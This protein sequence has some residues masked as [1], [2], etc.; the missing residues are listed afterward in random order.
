MLSAS[1]LNVFGKPERWK[2]QLHAADSRECSKNVFCTL[3]M[4]SHHPDTLNYQLWT[5]KQDV[6]VHISSLDA[7]NHHQRESEAAWDQW[8]KRWV[9]DPDGPG[10]QSW[11]CCQLFDRVKLLT[12]SVSQCFPPSPLGLIQRGVWRGL[13]S[14][15][16]LIPLYSAFIR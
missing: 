12:L 3:G 2:K 6:R 4:P 9:L 1:R 5:K 7:G 16:L 15:R 13:A 11:L 14:A 10:P 8:G